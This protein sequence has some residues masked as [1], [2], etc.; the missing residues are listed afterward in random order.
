MTFN[1]WC[2]GRRFRSH[3]RIAVEAVWNALIGGG[4]KPVECGRL[5]DDLFES[6]EVDA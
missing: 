5:L 4:M 3:T 1:Q 2:A 6:I